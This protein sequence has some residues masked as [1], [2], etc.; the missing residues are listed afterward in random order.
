MNIINNQYNG[1]SNI[2]LCYSSLLGEKEEKCYDELLSSLLTDL[3]FSEIF[4][5][6]KSKENIFLEFDQLSEDKKCEIIIK[7]FFIIKSEKDQVITEYHKIRNELE[8]VKEKE[9]QE[10]SVMIEKY[11][12][13]SYDYKCQNDQLK[14]QI[15]NLKSLKENSSKESN[16]K[17]EKY[18]SKISELEK[19]IPKYEKDKKDIETRLNEEIIEVPFL[20]ILDE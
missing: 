10:F 15:S 14:M 20:I 11:K 4:Q 8:K 18:K 7:G 13:E 6:I 2:K 1:N 19:L 3:E 12:K 9:E 5:E 17:L 16:N